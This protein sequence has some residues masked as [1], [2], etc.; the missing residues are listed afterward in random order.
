MEWLYSRFKKCEKI[1]ELIL[2]LY[3]LILWFFETINYPKGFDTYVSVNGINFKPL[4]FTALGNNYGG[5]T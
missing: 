2:Q 4:N 1:Y 5:L 3:N